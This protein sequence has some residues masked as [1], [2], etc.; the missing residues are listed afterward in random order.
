MDARRNDPVRLQAEAL[1]FRSRDPWLEHSL[2]S[3]LPRLV[4]S[5]RQ[6]ASCQDRGADDLAFRTEPCESWNYCLVCF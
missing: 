2:P 3:S 1:F 5:R 4:V 6:P